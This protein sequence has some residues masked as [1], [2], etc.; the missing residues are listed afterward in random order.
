MSGG[1]K[2]IIKHTLKVK[3]SIG[4]KKLKKETNNFL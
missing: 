3:D 2:Q 1:R 4:L